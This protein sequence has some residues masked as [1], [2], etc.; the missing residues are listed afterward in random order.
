VI[1]MVVLANIGFLVSKAEGQRR[2]EGR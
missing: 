1:F 2:Q